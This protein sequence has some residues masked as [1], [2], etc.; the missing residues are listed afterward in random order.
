VKFFNNEINFKLKS[1]PERIYLNEGKREKNFEFFLKGNR[2]YG[3]L[4]VLQEEVEGCQ[5]DFLIR[6]YEKV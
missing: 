4:W 3:G 1:E 2:R 5:G 6:F